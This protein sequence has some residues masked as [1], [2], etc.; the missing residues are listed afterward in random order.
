MSS[1]GRQYYQIRKQCLWA[2]IT[3]T[4][5]A[6]GEKKR[7]ACS[8]FASDLQQLNAQQSVPPRRA[9]LGPDWARLGQQASACRCSYACTNTLQ[10]S[11]AGTRRLLD[12]TQRIGRKIVCLACYFELMTHILAK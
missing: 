11:A 2:S 5:L 12:E 3:Q 4:L 8:K 7:D 10:R 6:R 1:P 9:G